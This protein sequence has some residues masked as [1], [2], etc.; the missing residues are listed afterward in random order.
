MLKSR[1]ARIRCVVSP[2]MFENEYAAEIAVPGGQSVSLFVDNGLV[3]VDPVTKEAML[4]VTLV[5]THLSEGE[6]TVLLPSEA[7]ENGSRWLRLPAGQV[8]VE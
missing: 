7:F 8:R 2:G 3:R 6:K 5:S 4:Q 1:H